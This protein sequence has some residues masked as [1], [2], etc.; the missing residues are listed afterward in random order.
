MA[1]PRFAGREDRKRR[2]FEL[3]RRDRGGAGGKAGA[4][5]VGAP[6]QARRA[7]GRGAR[8]AVRAR[9]SADRRARICSRPSSRGPVSAVRFGSCASGFRLGER[10]SG[11]G[12]PAARARRRHRSSPGRTRLL[13]GRRRRPRA[14][15]CDMSDATAHGA[16]TTP[17]D[18]WSTVD[19]RHEARHD[20]VSRLCDR[21]PDRPRRLCR[22]GL[23]MT[24]GE[25]PHPGGRKLLEAGAGGGGRSR[26]AGALDRGRAHGDHLRRRHQQCH[27]L[28]RQHARRRAWRRRRAVRRALQCRSPRRMDERAARASSGWR[29]AVRAEMAALAERGI[30]HVPGF[31]HRFHP[32]RSA[33]APPAGA[34]RRRGRRRRR[35]RALRR[36][37]PGGRGAACSGKGTADPDEYRRRHRR[38]LRRARLSAA[39]LPR[40]VRACPARSAP[41]PMPWKRCSPA[42]A[43]KDQSHATCSGPILVRRRASLPRRD[44]P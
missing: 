35:Q 20:P 25:L 13:E 42:N 31:G 41:W 44:V 21:G 29:E 9:A 5:M 28:G 4:G 26:P 32:R 38:G 15:R 1:D 22:D 23:P 2:R 19:H 3:E 27:G 8:R 39:A 10:R 17:E 18:W 43:T 11:A 7:G 12:I 33:R 37:R 30:R 40:P 36:H 14:R 6:E 24:R 34:G 16:S